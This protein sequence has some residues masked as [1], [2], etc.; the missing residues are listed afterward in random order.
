MRSL[1]F[2]A[3]VA[4][5]TF[6]A[7]FYDAV[8]DA[9]LRPGFSALDKDGNDAISLEELSNMPNLRGILNDEDIEAAFNPLDTNKDHHIS[10]DDVDGILDLV[11]PQLF[12]EALNAADKD[13]NHQISFDEAK[14]FLKDIYE[15]MDLRALKRSVDQG[16]GNNPGEIG[17][18]AYLE[19][20]DKN[21]D[22]R[23]SSEEIGNE[24]D[25][26]L[27]GTIKA[28]DKNNDNQVS[29]EEVKATVKDVV[30][31]FIDALDRDGDDK[32][33]LD[34]IKY[35]AN[36]DTLPNTIM[37]TIDENGDGQFTYNE[38]KKLTDPDVLSTANDAI[39][40]LDNAL[41]SGASAVAEWKT[42][43]SIVGFGIVMS[44]YH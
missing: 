19:R 7:A 22:G 31:K 21:G 34:E 30:Q 12:N 44:L 14:G 36:P 41:H 33:S 2:L 6:A 16:N 28:F 23:L 9:L 5:T 4:S 43:A 38:F 40:R 11:L 13:R 1:L 24:F 26:Y 25:I 3:A 39:D 20:M 18:L 37:K 29:L 8:K 10:Y 27:R 17:A 42:C 32:I 35:L 15:E